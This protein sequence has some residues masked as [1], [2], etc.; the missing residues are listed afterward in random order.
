MTD[1]RRSISKLQAEFAWRSMPCAAHVYGPL[2]KL[3]LIALAA[4]VSSART[5]IGIA[6]F[7]SAKDGKFVVS[8]A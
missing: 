4:I 1:T 3:A 7:A 5:F 8:S 2:V 6:T